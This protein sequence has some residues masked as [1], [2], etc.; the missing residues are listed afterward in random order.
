MRLP[1]GYGSVHKLSG[2]RRKP[3]RV[4]K[5]DGIDEYGK[6]KYLNIG[7]FEDR[8]SAYQALAEYNS[9]PWDVKAKDVTFGQIYEM[10]LKQ[11]EKEV[12][13]KSFIILKSIF[14]HTKPLQNVPVSKIKTQQMQELLNSLDRSQ[15]IKRKVKTVFTDVFK[16]C[17]KNDIVKKDYAALVDVGK[18]VKQKKEIHIFEPKE[19]KHLCNNINSLHDEITL[20]LVCTGFRI[21]ELLTLEVEN[22]DLEK[23]IMIGGSKTEAGKERIVPISK[24][25]KPIIEKYCANKNKYLLVNT[26]GNLMN[27]DNLRRKWKEDYPKHGFHDCRHTFSSICN[28]ADMKKLSQQRIMGH[29]PIDITDRVYTHKTA[30]DLILEMK[31]FDVYFEN[32]I[33]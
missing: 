32:M 18:P 20:L 24:F 27:A 16:Y 12:T 11:K 1:N 15:T 6:V 28:N 8:T 30:D 3:W 14:T 17:L 22:I 2:N 25:I 10:I 9:E 21:N 4:R 5:H 33:K 31:K 23:N 7:Y 26:K 29:S 13:P 19:I